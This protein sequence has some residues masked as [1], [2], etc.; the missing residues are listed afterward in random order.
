MEDAAT[1]NIRRADDSEELASRVRRDAMAVAQFSGVH[2]K[3]RVWIPDHDVRVPIRDERARSPGQS[4]KPR[5]AAHPFTGRRFDAACARAGQ[6]AASDSCSEAMPPMRR[7][8]APVCFISGGQGSGPTRRD[9]MSPAINAF[10]AP[11][12][13]SS[14]GWAERICIPVAPSGMSSA[15]NVR[16]VR[17]RFDGDRGRVRARRE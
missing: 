14:R 16:I 10:L 7:R 4:R 13:L 5:G 15:A 17:T 11:L 3:P 12:A 6:T 2:D 1:S 8:V 9:R